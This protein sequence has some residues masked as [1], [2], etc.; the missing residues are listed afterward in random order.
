MSED[1]VAIDPRRF[2]EVCGQYATG[3]AVVT[4]RCDQGRPKGV[5]VNSF[6]SVSLDPPLVQFS[7]DRK[8]SIFPI[9]QDTTHFVVNVLS[10]EQRPLSSRFALKSDA[11]EEVVYAAGA[12][13]CPVLHGCLANL[14]CEKFAVYD[15]GDHVIILGRVRQ[16]HCAPANEPLLFFRGSY[17]TFT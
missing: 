15:G 14:E 6:T 7:L 4:A 11:F 8:A 1:C 3:V 2:R 10:S 9:F 17:G 5:T 13:G 12:D 16:L